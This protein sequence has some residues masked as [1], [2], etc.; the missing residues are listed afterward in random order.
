QEVVSVGPE[1]QLL[2]FGDA[3]VLEK[4]KVGVE[5]AGS[6]NDRQGR[7]TVL[8]D[9]LREAE[10][11]L[12]DVLVFGEV[13]ARV[14]SQGRRERQVRRAEEGSVAHVVGRAGDLE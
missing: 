13:F 8:A 14:A 10:A 11:A 2:S 12:V 3:E 9:A 1:L 7:G 5:V 4:T 6:V